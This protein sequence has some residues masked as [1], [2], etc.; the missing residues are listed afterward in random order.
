MK[1]CEKERKGD[2]I[3]L[4]YPPEDLPE[5][6]LEEFWDSTDLPEGYLRKRKWKE[7]D[8]RPSPV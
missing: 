7:S 1:N 5:E 3:N 4:N 8:A 2:I 6:V